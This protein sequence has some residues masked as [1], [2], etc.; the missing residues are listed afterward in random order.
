MTS[1]TLHR[2]FMILILLMLLFSIHV[3]AARI[4]YVDQNAVQGEGN[5][6]SWENAFTDFQKALDSVGVIKGDVELRISKGVY[7]PGETTYT[8]GWRSGFDRQTLTIVGGYCPVN[9]SKDPD[10]LTTFT[11]EDVSQR[12]KNLMAVK[13]TQK[14]RD[15]LV[16]KRL[17]FKDNQETALSVHT[18]HIAIKECKFVNNTSTGDGGAINLNSPYSAKVIDSKFENNKANRGGSVYFY[19]QRLYITGDNSFVAD[20]AANGGSVY[21]ISYY[22]SIIDATFRNC[23]SIDSTDNEGFGGGAVN[24]ESD[25]IILKSSTFENNS[26]NSNA[27]AVYI[28][29]EESTII[30]CS[31]VDNSSSIYGG[32]VVNF[33]ILTTISDNRFYQNSAEYG[34]A[35]NLGSGGNLEANVFEKNVASYMG[36]AIY[37]SGG[38][39]LRLNAFELEFL[40]NEAQ[41][42]GAWVPDKDTVVVNNS[43]F[44]GNKADSVGGVFLF[45]QPTCSESASTYGEIFESNFDSNMA[46]F[47]GVVSVASG[48]RALFSNCAFKSNEAKYGGGV[49]YGR[50][51]HSTVLDRSLITENSADYGSVA[52]NWNGKII[53]SVV[54]NNDANYTIYSDDHSEM[55]PEI[56]NSTFTQNRSDSGSAGLFNSLVAN[57][58]L[59]END[60][61]E[62]VFDEILPH[63]ETGNNTTPLYSIISDWYYGGEGNSSRNP[64]FNNV[65]ERNFSLAPN[66][67]AIN[68]GSVEFY[69][70]GL[71][72]YDFKGNNRVFGEF[73]D[74]GAFEYQ[75]TALSPPCILSTLN[76]FEIPF[77]DNFEINLAKTNE[78]NQ[79]YYVSCTDQDLM[80]LSW[81]VK[82]VPQ[83]ITVG[84]EPLTNTLSVKPDKEWLPADSFFITVTVCD[85][86]Y[87]ELVSER[88]VKFIVSNPGLNLCNIEVMQNPA[89]RDFL[90]T[91]TVA[92]NTDPIWFQSERVYLYDGLG[93]INEY[94]AMPYLEGIE[95]FENSKP[96]S[97]GGEQRCGEYQFSF[98][99]TSSNVY[100]AGGVFTG[101]TL[102]DWIMDS[103]STGNINY[104][105][106]QTATFLF[107]FTDGVQVELSKMTVDVDFD[108]P[109]TNLYLSQQ[110][111]HSLTLRW[112][113]FEKNLARLVLNVI[114][115][116][117]DAPEN[118][119]IDLGEEHIQQRR[120]TVDSLQDSR[121]Y[122]FQLKAVD[123]M[124]N[125]GISELR[126]STKSGYY[127]VSG[128][129]AGNQLPGIDT[130]T[131]VTV[132][133]EGLLN[134]F[135]MS[136]EIGIGET[137]TFDNVPN[138]V[139]HI[140]A[141]SDMYSTLPSVIDTVVLRS[142][143]TGINFILSPHNVI[144]DDA[145]SVSQEEGTGDLLFRVQ[146]EELFYSEHPS[147]IMLS[148]EGDC[149]SLGTVA[150]SQS[151]I[152]DDYG[153][154]DL[155]GN[156]QEWTFR[157]TRQEVEDSILTR[158]GGFEYN[159][160]YIESRISTSA[161]GYS[162]F[163]KA[164]WNYP[165]YSNEVTE[166]STSRAFFMYA[167]QSFRNPDEP[168]VTVPLMSR[169]DA[170]FLVQNRRLGIKTDV[171][172]QF[173]QIRNGEFYGDTL[174]STYD[175][176]N[177]S[178]QNDD[179]WIIR[180]LDWNT[181]YTHNTSKKD[182]YFLS[183]LYIEGTGG[184]DD[185]AYVLASGGSFTNTTNYT[186]PFSPE[187]YTSWLIDIPVDNNYS[188]SFFVEEANESDTVF[189]KI[190][191]NIIA[192]Y[193]IKSSE[194]G[195]QRIEN[196]NYRLS[197]G[198]KELKI[199][200]APNTETIITAVAL[201]EDGHAGNVPE[202]N[203][204]GFSAIKNR[205]LKLN[206]FNLHEDAHYRAEVFLKDRYGNRSESVI[207]DNLYTKDN[208]FTGDVII[209]QENTSGDLVINI[210]KQDDR[211]LS[212]EEV[213]F[214][215]DDTSFSVPVN[216]DIENT[217]NTEI[218][219][220]RSDLSELISVDDFARR[221]VYDSLEFIVAA[222]S[223]YTNNYSI[224]QTINSCSEC[225]ESNDTLIYTECEIRRT[226]K[227]TFW[228][229][230]KTVTEYT[231]RYDITEII[232]D[233][234]QATMRS[235]WPGGTQNKVASQEY[236]KVTNPQFELTDKTHRSVTLNSTNLNKIGESNPKEQ[237]AGT[238]YMSWSP[239]SLCEEVTNREYEF[240][241]L[242]TKDE[243]GWISFMPSF[244]ASLNSGVGQWIKHEGVGA[245]HQ[246]I[247]R[248][249]EE[250]GLAGGKFY[251]PI[252]VNY[253]SHDFHGNLDGIPFISYGIYLT[254]EQ[255]S[256]DRSSEEE[257]Y[258]LWYLP[259]EGNTESR[260]KFYWFVND[261]AIEM[262]GEPVFSADPD[263][264]Q[265]PA[266]YLD[267]GISTID[268]YMVDDGVGIDGIALSKG[269]EA[270]VFSKHELDTWGGNKG[271]EIEIVAND[272]PSNEKITF[273]YV[274]VDRYGNMSDSGQLEKTTLENEDG[275][276]G[277]VITPE[278][279][280]EN[281]YY[282]S[283]TPAFT[284][285][286]ESEFDE[287]A[288]IEA[289]LHK[290]VDG[291]EYEMV[292]E[293]ERND[294][295]VNQWRVFNEDGLIEFPDQGVSAQN[296][297]VLRILPSDSEGKPGNWV[298]QRF[299]I[300]AADG[301]TPPTVTIINPVYETAYLKF[302]YLNGFATADNTIIGNLEVLFKDGYGPHNENSKLILE[303]ATIH[304]TYTEDSDGTIE[305]QYIDSLSYGEFAAYECDYW[306]E[307][308]S[309]INSFSI[310]YGNY[311]FEVNADLLSMETDHSGEYKIYSQETVLYDDRDNPA[312]LSSHLDRQSSVPFTKYGVI[313]TFYSWRDRFFIR[314]VVK[315][316]PSRDGFSLD[317]CIMTFS[318]DRSGSNDVFEMVAQ[319]QCHN[320]GPN[321]TFT[322]L[323]PSSLRPAFKAF[324]LLDRPVDITYTHSDPELVV[325]YGT[326]GF[327]VENSD[328]GEAIYRG[329]R[330]KVDEYVFN[331][332]GVTVNDMSIGLNEETFPPQ[333]NDNNSFVPNF[334]G[335]EIR[336]D[337]DLNQGALHVRGS[338]ISEANDVS[339]TTRGDY[340]FTD[341]SK[342]RFGYAQPTD[343]EMT[344][345]EGYNLKAPTWKNETLYPNESLVIPV[346]ASDGFILGYE[347]IRK[348]H[349]QG[350]IERTFKEKQEN[351][352]SGRLPITIRKGYL[353][354]RG[355]I[356]ITYA[357]RNFQV[358]VTPNETDSLFT[359]A[360]NFFKNRD[361]EVGISRGS[362]GFFSDFSV[363]TLYAKKMGGGRYSVVPKQFGIAPITAPG[364][365]IFHTSEGV[366]ILL[367]APD[368]QLGGLISNNAGDIFEMSSDCNFETS[369]YNAGFNVAGALTNISGR[370]DLPDDI[371]SCFGIGGISN[372]TQQVAQFS[373]RSIMLGYEKGEEHDKLT[374]G[375]DASIQL[376]KAFS[377]IGM[378]GEKILLSELT[379]SYSNNTWA[380][381]TMRGSGFTTPRTFNLGNRGYVELLNGGHG[382][383][384]GYKKGENLNVRMDNWTLRTTEK[385]PIEGL[386]NISLILDSLIYEK[387]LNGG[388]DKGRI[389]AIG[390]SMEYVPPNG[391]LTIG[392]YG[393]GDVVLRVSADG[394]DAELEGDE[395]GN[396]SG[397]DAYFSLEFGYIQI[398]D[399]TI[400]TMCG[401]QKSEIRIYF[402]GR[403]F[404]R[405][406]LTWNQKIGVVPWGDTDN[407]TLFIDPGESGGSVGFTIE[408]GKGFTGSLYNVK[409]RSAYSIPVLG[410][411]NVD[412]NRLSFGIQDGK[413][414][415]DTLDVSWL[416]NRTI[417]DYDIAKIS[418][419]EVNFG[420]N[421]DIP[422]NI[423]LENDGKSFWIGMQP[424][425][426]FR[427]GESCELDID[428]S[429]YFV[430][431]ISES[432][433]DIEFIYNFGGGFNCEI[434]GMQFGSGIEVRDGYFGLPDSYIDLSKL[435]ERG[436][437]KKGA[438]ARVDF[439]NLNWERVEGEWKLN[440]DFDTEVDL[441]TDHSFNICGL[442]VNGT[443]D[444]GRLF[445]SGRERGVGFTGITL[446]M[447][448]NFG[449]TEIPIGMNLFING[450]KP[451]LHPEF[452][453]PNKIVIPISGLNLTDNISLFSLLMEFG[454]E[455]REESQSRSW[456]FR[457]KASMDLKGAV[458]NVAVDLSLERPQPRDNITGINH[459]ILTIKL[460]KSARIPLGTT[461]AYISGFRG[462]MYDGFGMPISAVECNIP[463]LPPGLKAEIAIFIEYEDPLVAQGS[464]G[465]WV[466]LR[467]L[468]FGLTGELTVL[469][470]IA[471]AQSC[472]ALYNNGS[473]F[474]GSFIVRMELGVAIEGGFRIDIWSDETGGN[475]TADASARIGLKRKTLINRR[476]LKIPRKTF[477][478]GEQ[479]VNAGKFDN[480][481][482]GFTTGFRFFRRSWGVGII[483]KKF[484]IGNMGK[485]R[486]KPAPIYQTAGTFGTMN[487][488]SDGSDQTAYMVTS[489]VEYKNPGLVLE[490]TEVISITSAVSSGRYEWPEEALR[491]YNPA[492][493][494]ELFSD[495][496]V[497]ES[498]THS[499][500]EETLDNL[501]A[502]SWENNGIKDSVLVA[503][504]KTLY[505]E[506][507]FFENLMFA[508]LRPA[509]PNVDATVM[510]TD[511]G[512][513]VVFSG[514]VSDFQFDTRDLIKIDEDGETDT[515]FRQRMDLKFF[516]SSLGRRDTL[517]R[518]KHM[519]N[520]LD[521]HYSQFEGYEEGH[522]SILDNEN[523]DFVY[524]ETKIG[525]PQGRV[526]KINDLALKTDQFSTGK[527]ALSVA[528]EIIDFV[529]EDGREGGKIILPDTALSEAA[530]FRNDPVVILSST[531][532]D[533]LSIDVVN[534][535]PA[536]A[537]RGLTATGSSV[538][539]EDGEFWPSKDETRSIYMKWEQ[540]YN[541]NISGYL[542][543]WTSDSHPEYSREAS[544]GKTNS[545]TITIPSIPDSIYAV[546]SASAQ[547]AMTLDTTYTI[548]V[549]SF[550]IDLSE[551]DKDR[552][553][554]VDTVYINDSSFVLRY[555]EK[556][557]DTSYEKTITA[558]D[559]ISPNKVYGKSLD[560]DFY[561]STSFTV[562]LTPVS[563]VHREVTETVH[564]WD[565]TVEITDTIPVDSI[566]EHLS[567]SVS[568]VELGSSGGS[569]KNDFD[570]TFDASDV[571]GSDPIPVP[572]NEG[573]TV[574]M[575]VDA[576]HPDIAIDEADAS[577][578][579]EIFA[580]IP[581]NY[582]ESGILDV[583]IP[584][585]GS[586]HSSFMVTEYEKPTGLTFTP[587]QETVT[588][589][590]MFGSS[591]YRTTRDGDS[592]DVCRD[593]LVCSD[594]DCENLDP[595]NPEHEFAQVGLCGG[596]P[597]ELVRKRTPFEEYTAYVAVVNNG[598]R[599][600][601]VNQPGPAVYDSVR[602][603]VTPP[604]PLVHNIS[605]DYIRK[606]K[607]DTL[608]IAVSNIWK[609]TSDLRA[610]AVIGWYNDDGSV[611]E[612][613]FDLQWN[614]NLF[615]MD[616][617]DNPDW[618]IAT[619]AQYQIRIP[620]ETI[621]PDVRGE[622]DLFV[623]VNNKDTTLSG[624][625]VA[626]PSNSFPVAF[627]H[628]PDD[629]ACPV[630]YHCD[631]TNAIYV[632]DFIGNY[633]L[634]PE[635]G[636]S[637]TVLFTELHDLNPDHYTIHILD[638]E[639]NELKEIE[640]FR[641]EYYGLWFYMPNLGTSG[642]EIRVVTNLSDKSNLPSACHDQDWG[643]R[644]PLTYSDERNYSIEQHGD[645]FRITLTTDNHEFA[646]N[647]VIR[648][649]FGHKKHRG[650]PEG[651]K[652][653]YHKNS[654]VSMES[655]NW[656]NAVITQ[657]GSNRDTLIKWIEVNRCPELYYTAGN[658]VDSIFTAVPGDTLIIKSQ[659]QD[660]HDAINRPEIYHCFTFADG[661][662]ECSDTIVIN[663]NMRSPLRIERKS[664][665]VHFDD[666]VRFECSREYTFDIDLPPTERIRK[667][668]IP[669]AR[670]NEAITSPVYNYPLLLRIDES[671]VDGLDDLINGYFNF[672][673][674]NMR[675]LPFEIE[676]IDSANTHIDVWVEM[677]TLD[678]GLGNNSI[679]I[680]KDT[681][682]HTSLDMWS[683]Y[684]AVYHLHNNHVLDNSAQNRFHIPVESDSVITDGV[685]GKGM[686]TNN[687]ITYEP[688][689]GHLLGLN[690]DGVT[691]SGWIRI[692]QEITANTEIVT[693]TDDHNTTVVT[694]ALSPE[695]A[696]KFVAGT[697][698]LS[699]M[700]NVVEM[701]EWLH[702][703]ATYNKRETENRGRIIVNGVQVAS[704]PMN[705]G[706]N[707]RFGNGTLHVGGDRYGVA[708][709]GSIDE[710]RIA[711]VAIAPEW[712]TLD[713]YTQRRLN[714]FLTPPA[715]VTSVTSVSDPAYRVVSS[716]DEKTPVF[717]NEW[718][719]NELPK[720]LSDNLLIQIPWYT[721]RLR[722]DTLFSVTLN[723][724]AKVT[725]LYDSR[726][727]SIPSFL[728]SYEGPEQRDVFLRS[729]K[730]GTVIPFDTYTKQIE[731]GGKVF[732][733]SPGAD[734][735]F[736]FVVLIDTQS[737]THHG[738][739]VS[740]QNTDTKIESKINEETLIFSDREYR[741]DS[742]PH[743]LADGVIVRTSNSFRNSKSN[744]R[745]TVNRP[746]RV[747]MLMDTTRVP[748]EE[749]GAWNDE[750]QRVRGKRLP[751]LSAGQEQ[752]IWFNLYSK[753]LAAGDFSVPGAGIHEVSSEYGYA[754]IVQEDTISRDTLPIIDT[755]VSVYYDSA[756]YIRYIPHHL[757]NA[758][759][760]RT[761]QADY[762]SDA[763]ELMH[764]E[765]NRSGYLYC[766]IERG[767]NS[768]PSFISEYDSN[769]GGWKPAN[770]IISTQ[771]QDFDL[772]KKFHRP[773]S[774]TFSGMRSGGETSN[775]YNYFFVVRDTVLPETI[776]P[777]MGQD[778]LRTGYL[779]PDV[780]P[781]KDRDA[782]ITYVTPDIRGKEFIEQN[783][784]SSGC[785]PVSFVT[786][787][788]VRVWVATDPKMRTDGSF[789]SEDKWERTSSV[790]SL[791]D[792]LED[793]V[794]WSR[795]FEPGTITIPGV[796]CDVFQPGVEN[797]I[798]AVEFYALPYRGYEATDLAVRG[799]GDERRAE[800]N[801]YIMED[802][803]IIY[804]AEVGMSSQ[805]WTMDVNL[806]NAAVEPGDT[807]KVLAPFSDSVIVQ[808]D[809]SVVVTSP[810]FTL[811]DL[812]PYHISAAD[813]T[814]NA[815]DLRS[816]GW[817]RVAFKNDSDVP[818]DQSFKV[819]L[820][821]DMDGDYR[822]NR[823][824]DRYIGR[825]VVDG[826][827]PNQSRLYQ[828]DIDSNLTYPNRVLFAFL[829]EYD[830]IEEFDKSN[831]IIYTGTTCEGYS[832][833]VYT[834]DDVFDRETIEANL[835][836]FR[837]T[838]LFAYLRD[839]DGDGFI[840]SNDSL[841]VVY[842]SDFKL[843]AVMAYT[844][845]PL[846]NP[847][848]VDMSSVTNLRVDDFTGTGVPEILI[849]S[850]IY[851][852]KGD[853]VIDL[854]DTVPPADLHSLPSFDFNR[855]GEADPIIYDQG[856]VMVR[857]GRDNTLLY[858][859]PFNSWTGEQDMVTVG[860]AADIVRGAYRC[861][862]LNVSYPR[863]SP[864]NE[865]STEVT[866]RI[867]NP[868]ASTIERGIDLTVYADG[869]VEDSLTS[870]VDEVTGR[871]DDWNER[872]KDPSVVS[873]GE[874]FITSDFHPGDFEDVTLKVRVP[875]GA[876]RLWFVIDGRNVYFE[877]NEEDNVVS[878]EL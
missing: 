291:E 333:K 562:T 389:K 871:R 782:V 179:G 137:Y 374:I 96:H 537:P 716:I 481:Q 362:I 460:D 81:G 437:M 345:P 400:S 705:N 365:D 340:T 796:H 95:I 839:T 153:H 699:T 612:E 485:Y 640:D 580:I 472:I 756:V 105:N 178:V 587:I 367:L 609:D 545:Y 807:M 342:L 691:L 690:D 40:E 35:L 665:D 586:R 89:G 319:G 435:V 287:T 133:L 701:N 51:Y 111:A 805:S 109:L 188:V 827:E 59:W 759:L 772:Y 49:G 771:F 230:T 263:W 366:R 420:Y 402:D 877:V 148:W 338:A 671:I 644:Q 663:S 213:K 180:H 574:R 341:I 44:R 858:V 817:V 476:W 279:P 436:I 535:A 370:I 844:N 384:L 378:E 421:A 283:V 856:F 417:M 139:Y 491:V 725:V 789:L 158:K 102:Y 569:D 176:T 106:D 695:G 108:A 667:I 143:L 709:P 206:N 210:Q 614:E 769:T 302:R 680:V 350:E 142:D 373:I 189:F 304:T 221:T 721:R 568:G 572:L 110:A 775:R 187:I 852:P 519:Y 388:N 733:G 67:P 876:Q 445:K 36:G 201:I 783:L 650:G 65:E 464:V 833:P 136:T 157:I 864:I 175:I 164:N 473:A 582:D 363:N 571:N 12:T 786:N 6:S 87:P 271:F 250:E 603:I 845:E 327:S 813:V 393:F 15:F 347:G 88:Q 737:P 815:I 268:I 343:F 411:V 596:K 243:N 409:L 483:D 656:V 256:A 584:S 645:G 826:L 380:L 129:I 624:I 199:Y 68:A 490:G 324:D 80:E 828:I 75:D 738:L 433:R 851:T 382:L 149:D 205:R 664:K 810:T 773:G 774:H 868:G 83:G 636:D 528:V 546:D 658:P 398:G 64:R 126:A 408:Q 592:V 696:V 648:Y 57:S 174:L 536:E 37:G 498:G 252:G 605:P 768:P 403:Y 253:R 195:W 689:S 331:E 282:M 146:T 746:A 576:T 676:R 261:E 348:V 242:Y 276:P 855:D 56:I 298:Q 161:L 186:Q 134:Q 520:Y 260:Q 743:K 192:D 530:V 38:Y 278:I 418:V 597:D 735:D 177:V 309:R 457:G 229:F 539:I 622:F 470:G 860:V 616:T 842:T 359:L 32:A 443:F 357:A 296:C 297:Y 4:V 547:G 523:I 244:E 602:F 220:D 202:N 615:K 736:P 704:K 272:I 715:G 463:E 731:Q 391:E 224:H 874:L 125:E 555:F 71:Y 611:T 18:P 209:H 497:E 311:T 692:E 666:R 683:T 812:V 800:S 99:S 3:T 843:H 238:L 726:K 870:A 275:V 316:S 454:V 47:G 739:R 307:F 17:K 780:A 78:F 226:E 798:I 225:I 53:N 657:N 303:G 163:R 679:Y 117:Q 785:R 216:V 377:N 356:L 196:L 829:D 255:A 649:F 494:S 85:P 466:H 449:G 295:N 846:F 717:N 652:K 27:G 262:G 685:I 277:A 734:A 489:D 484:K 755:G 754:F 222:E 286:L 477:W 73:I 326:D 742:L 744:N 492:D 604:R 383:S 200:G 219:I 354:L 573:K 730:S 770:Q 396:K 170:D 169:D 777:E 487:V 708:F 474:H 849:G 114:P 727:V 434:A 859:H 135:T 801:S 330:V 712:H 848:Y 643:I 503:Y 578:Y 804:A 630:R 218:V 329:W 740:A 426:D 265:G 91:V 97:R 729:T 761:Y 677:D 542:V 820:F 128:N 151:F 711:P 522:T 654:V 808:S 42:G 369:I 724:P 499:D 79:G 413:A 450:K 211:S 832:Q 467:R 425:V 392:N 237:M 500:Y 90:G 627:I 60:G 526:L 873:V 504:P 308:C 613:K 448:D 741:L 122:L 513:V 442:T 193:V 825:I 606:G 390:A 867:A 76:D 878:Y 564:L 697:D 100:T 246:W 251:P 559:E 9:N 670:I 167:P 266:V 227:R 305:H 632:M 598:R 233:T 69:P 328:I 171:V 19:G 514:S 501:R 830:Q 257:R 795:E 496:L 416:V 387:D 452:D 653:T 101:K 600:V 540:D 410:D 21:S 763:R 184:E 790:I 368:F 58:I 301:E 493:T 444:F 190:G 82:T 94:E 16:L 355:D 872:R 809:S 414:S 375:T 674:S 728:G 561:R 718:I 591:C 415:L 862:D 112:N 428:P 194:S 577:G 364:F 706:R 412:V 459:A 673:N 115:Q 482:S 270:P 688:E 306:G 103:T 397:V 748:G 599:D 552:A 92:G 525:T 280:L 439:V 799:I 802:L 822:Y 541:P 675:H 231:C 168:L 166:G 766:A 63:S 46:N 543:T 458:N 22:S 588:C 204:V 334:S 405:G 821:E 267:S 811:P 847:F 48:A 131:V 475:F 581:N 84:I 703:A 853:K 273:S 132:Q 313:D 517:S 118:F 566:H 113:S 451:F 241:N 634:Y 560:I 162:Q 831:N 395:I 404:V 620:V 642:Q 358:R 130:T 747:T 556:V 841:A 502:R 875:E 823:F 431:D 20:R 214:Y 294:E 835:P 28:R 698:T 518:G 317:A 290:V 70:V 45:L 232:T 554:R 639:N 430:S 39:N 10:S 678:P 337:I 633:P 515:L 693:L 565:E 215:F 623:Y 479:F 757:E 745:F 23:K 183:G 534:N 779:Y 352:L 292:V 234:V 312:R 641:V 840:D 52:Y 236:R 806:K 551:A 505:D 152:I 185:T 285:T 385:F 371:M 93:D 29:G 791:S 43:V 863:L 607:A 160:R 694:L 353:T 720:H 228:W 646:K 661:T 714:D 495:N 557:R 440:E 344:M 5:G 619:A 758:G 30:G 138:D 455:Q 14:D 381:E 26:S 300:I 50:S 660:G 506:E 62:F 438:S 120:I 419:R 854:S 24:V 11:R 41:F 553:D 322:V 784:F 529:V 803:D 288:D 349:A 172:V 593:S 321:L 710:L 72:P 323:D 668:T 217:G 655:S 181:T 203:S 511:S 510:D 575:Q 563:T 293:I 488:M 299:G 258:T 814:V 191:D 332:H 173:N 589:R 74:I 662:S 608:S 104:K 351:K 659:E 550:Y 749:F 462:A 508:G 469:E 141:I 447:S 480:E 583:S 54:Y 281:G 468:N 834:E 361:E 240:G 524:D 788:P 687:T 629:I 461:G 86:L 274:A 686:Y 284:V 441:T 407:P 672:R 140:S 794:V 723:G 866:V 767:V 558:V 360:A 289:T 702:V 245:I 861:Y 339:L 399:S 427:L 838:T 325:D 61:E 423:N 159:V 610:E 684:R 144:K 516:L 682:E 762:S 320:C 512:Q 197:S 570:I 208:S 618:Q 346:G 7:D 223:T 310:P 585:V 751:I 212:V 579:G 509:K 638:D 465:F 107:P 594:E 123:L 155:P 750:S 335:L 1:K 55:Y 239:G 621:N 857:S 116:G 119:S 836:Q 379:T 98:N 507:V 548:S 432:S 165:S 314:D 315:Y 406:C 792:D 33:T 446:K 422:D 521:I 601:P 776:E 722:E 595:N 865:D 707:L 532:N 13:W 753:R 471:T 394:K 781:F 793:R 816:R 156:K 719:I 765:M 336:G 850:K 764:I 121:E 544:I 386:R 567:V 787:N 651:Y 207:F 681:V 635:V 401:D 124:G 77:N 8:I 25:T 154:T 66:S 247:D 637:V 145:V 248:Y 617:T 264:I 700:D 182:P 254:Q 628:N 424:I 626:T 818:V 732:F 538:K 127:T 150:D 259:S 198:V 713:F 318:R 625:D 2:K 869:V 531:T 837:D 527:Y 372:I 819:V 533:I 760:V 249:T 778:P 147:E 34:G 376:G 453:Q 590:E 269:T 669:S 797:P 647:D 456:Y 31:F 549:D 478:L 486:L 235:S 752:D 824:V 429:I 631:S